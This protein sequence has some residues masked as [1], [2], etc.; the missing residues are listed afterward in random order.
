MVSWLTRFSAAMEVNI[1]SWIYG[2]NATSLPEGPVLFRAEHSIF[3]FP[4][5]VDPSRYNQDNHLLGELA[6]IINVSLK[7]THSESLVDFF[8]TFTT[9]PP[10]PT[11]QPLSCETY[12]LPFIDRTRE[13]KPG[14]FLRFGS[15]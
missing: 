4:F 11:T 6:E 10:T 12:S 8:G 5:L 2:K 3:I 9:F 14:S 15:V 1:R 7:E 13:I